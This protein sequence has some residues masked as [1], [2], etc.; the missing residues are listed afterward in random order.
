MSNTA[1][2][3]GRRVLAEIKAQHRPKSI[4]SKLSGTEDLCVWDDRDWPCP[5]ARAVEAI[6]EA[7][8]QVTPGEPDP[9]HEDC[10]HADC[11]RD[12][13]LAKLAP[14]REGK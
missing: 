11:A 1:A 2:A 4:T 5:M 14:R 6:E 9:A 13:I 10:N 3:E 7:L 8:R 12:A